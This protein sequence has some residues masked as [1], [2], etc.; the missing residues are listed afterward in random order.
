MKIVR[1]HKNFTLRGLGDKIQDVPVLDTTLGKYQKSV[2]DAMRLELIDVSELEQLTGISE[3]YFYFDANCVFTEDFLKLAILQIKSHGQN[4]SYQI[5]LRLTECI[6]RFSLPTEENSATRRLPFYFQSGNTSD[7]IY[8]E[9]EG[10]EFE[11]NT[12]MPP[13]I[14]R[15][16]H[17]SLNQ[18]SVFAATII[19]PFHLL[20]ANMG[21]NMNRCIG[22]QRLIPRALR[23]TL[24]KPFSRFAIMGL[25]TI[26]R[27]GKNCK[28]HPSAIIEGCI[29]GDNVTIGANCVIRLSI[30]GDGTFIGDAAIVTYSVIGERNFVATGNQL[31]LCLTYPDVFT[32]HGPYQFTLFGK[33]SSVFAT[34]NCDI[35]LDQKTIRIDTDHGV[36]DSEQYLLGI[37]YGHDTKVGGSN[38]IAAGRFVPNNTVLNP[39]DFIHLKFPDDGQ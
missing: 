9:L 36:I 25:K 18:N 12:P 20:Q 19:S 11:L 10:E 33:S 35:R 28:I 27:K 37:S 13:Q 6:Q 3:P 32:I 24:S 8:L 29:I 7:V 4:A 30:I 2:C 22:L 17:Y 16:G 38:I 23:K 5:G 1:V 39:P 15:T 31:S 26:N 14:V 21:L 34:I